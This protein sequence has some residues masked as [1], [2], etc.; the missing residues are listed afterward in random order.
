M[1]FIQNKNNSTYDKEKTSIVSFI[2]LNV[3]LFFT[4]KKVGQW[5]FELMAI[6]YLSFG[7]IKETP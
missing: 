2:L 3:V 7:D 4:L 5:L 6:E 1:K